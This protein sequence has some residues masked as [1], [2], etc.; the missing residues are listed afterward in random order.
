MFV[1]F[2]A[3][4]S[5]FCDSKYGYAKGFDDGRKQAGYNFG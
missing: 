1:K 5:D 3:N 4:R 2:F